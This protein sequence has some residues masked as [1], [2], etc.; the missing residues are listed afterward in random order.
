MPRNQYSYLTIKTIIEE[1]KAEGLS[2]SRNTFYRLESDGL[3]VSQKTSRG[4]RR[5]TRDEVDLIKRLIKEN[6]AIE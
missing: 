4:W 6:Y 2:I 3:F 5:Y 1:L